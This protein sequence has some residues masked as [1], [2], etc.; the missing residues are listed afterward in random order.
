MVGCDEEWNFNEYGKGTSKNIK[1]MVVVLPV[2]CLQYHEAL[3][4]LEV[5]LDVLDETCDIMNLPDDADGGMLDY[6]LKNILGI[7]II[8]KED[9][10]DV[11]E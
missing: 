7:E 11:E 5:L 4:A 1:R 3:V 9:C 10:Y 6:I 2:I 8:T